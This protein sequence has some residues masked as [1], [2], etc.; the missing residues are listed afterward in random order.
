M[1]LQIDTEKV[2]VWDN[3]QFKMVERTS[4]SVSIVGNKGTVYAVEG[5]LICETGY[6]ICE[7]ARILKE[8]LLG[9]L[10]QPSGYNE[11]YDTVI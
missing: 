7:A 2:L 1:G 4:V 3:T 11:P 8:R 6:D 10:P 5:P 9:R